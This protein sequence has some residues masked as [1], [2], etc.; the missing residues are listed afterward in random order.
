MP[1]QTEKEYFAGRAAT[2]RAAGQAAT[3]PAIA[4]AHNELARR[5]ALVSAGQTELSA[6]GFAIP[7]PQAVPRPVVQA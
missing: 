7:E 5:Y 3:D 4:F 6:P 2:S 1:F